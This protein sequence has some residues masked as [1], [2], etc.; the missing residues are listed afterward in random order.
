MDRAT[1]FPPDKTFKMYSTLTYI[2]Y[3]FNLGS[4]AF[5]ATFFKM[6]I[7]ST[8]AMFTYANLSTIIRFVQV[9][10]WKRVMEID[11]ELASAVI[12]RSVV[13]VGFLLGCL[14]HPEFKLYGIIS[15]LSNLPTEMPLASCKDD[16]DPLHQK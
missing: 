8:Y 3:R 10:V 6:Y 4:A 16:I 2:T 5:Q 11:E 1:D 9:V 15:V 14:C 7:G 13:G 12:N